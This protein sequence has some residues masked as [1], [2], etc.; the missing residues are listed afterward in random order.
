MFNVHNS[1]PYGELNSN[2]QEQFEDTYG[3]I[4]HRKSKK[5]IQCNG[6]KKKNKHRCKAIHRKIKIEQDEP[7]KNLL[8]I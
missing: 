6:R 5:D 7:H 1:L 4:R 8:D 3:V 2:E